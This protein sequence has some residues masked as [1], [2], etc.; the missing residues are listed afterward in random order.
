M[1]N[2]V[3]AVYMGIRREE[4]NT[5]DVVCEDEDL[6]VNAISGKDC[7]HGCYGLFEA[8]LGA[9]RNVTMIKV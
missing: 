1:E 9:G 7:K 5:A 4:K 2:Q 8:L 6:A 3:L